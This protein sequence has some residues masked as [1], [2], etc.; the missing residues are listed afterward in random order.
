[1]KQEQPW[2]LW[3]YDHLPWLYPEG[4]GNGLRHHVGNGRIYVVELSLE[5][6]V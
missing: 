5:K 6:R 4:A 3:Q 1:M 2:F